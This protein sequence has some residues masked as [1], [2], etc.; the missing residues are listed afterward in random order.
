MPRILLPSLMPSPAQ[1]K[2][3]ISGVGRIGSLGLNRSSVMSSSGEMDNSSQSRYSARRRT[4]S[5]TASTTTPP[6]VSTSTTIATTS[7]PEQQSFI[8]D[9][10]TDVSDE[11]G[12]FVD[13]TPTNDFEGQQRNFLNGY[14]ARHRSRLATIGDQVAISEEGY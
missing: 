2:A 3:G 5:G 11:W 8:P 1:S 7:S 10:Q 14:D 9:I 6:P 12:F 4:S 13:P